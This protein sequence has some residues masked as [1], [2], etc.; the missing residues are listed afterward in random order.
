MAE[1]VDERLLEL[2]EEQE[3][4]G[5]YGTDDQKM[6]DDKRCLLS[7]MNFRCVA[8]GSAIEV[9]FGILEVWCVVSIVARG[10]ARAPQHIFCSSARP[11]ML[12][13]TASLLFHSW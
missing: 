5:P 10:V 6:D 3:Q 2:V 11:T 1:R 9:F 7:C 8:R 12:S 13:Y 4:E